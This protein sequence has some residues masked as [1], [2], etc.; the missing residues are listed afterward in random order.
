MCIKQCKKAGP[1]NCNCPVFYQIATKL[2]Q[3]IYCKVNIVNLTNCWIKAQRS[4]MQNNH[5]NDKL[6]CDSCKKVFVNSELYTKE[7]LKHIFY[8]FFNFLKVESNWETQIQKF[9]I[10]F[11]F[12]FNFIEFFRIV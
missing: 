11:Y 6:S 3:T 5:L 7:R 4:H 1:R 2:Q 9:S 10:I 12:F 8:F